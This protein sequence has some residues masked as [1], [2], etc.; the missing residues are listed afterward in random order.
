V[1]CHIVASEVIRKGRGHVVIC[2]APR[3]DPVQ[4]ETSASRAP[5]TFVPD[6]DLE[7]DG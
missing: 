1:G 7:A 2:K 4:V 5:C 3:G 6:E